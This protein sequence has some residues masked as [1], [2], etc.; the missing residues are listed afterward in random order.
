MKPYQQ[1]N[2][3]IKKL[4]ELAIESADEA[5]RFGAPDFRQVQIERSI[6]NILTK[7]YTKKRQHPKYKSI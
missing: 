1:I 6:K 2:K 4:A 3:D 5:Q 7:Y